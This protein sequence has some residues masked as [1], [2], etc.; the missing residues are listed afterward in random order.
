MSVFTA[1]HLQRTKRED[2][3]DKKEIKKNN[4]T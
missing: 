1:F 3:F 4:K 2:L